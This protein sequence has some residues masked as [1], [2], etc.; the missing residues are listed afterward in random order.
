MVIIPLAFVAIFYLIVL[1]LGNHMLN[2]TVEE[3]ENRVTEMM[4]TTMSPTTMISGKIVA[5]AAVGLLQILVFV[6]IPVVALVAFRDK[7]QI[8]GLDLKDI[9]AEPTQV[10]IGILLLLGGLTLFT[11][12]LVAAGAVMPTAK[13]ASS[14]FGA[15]VVGLFIPFYAISLIVTDP[16]SLIVNIFTFFPLTAP[17]TAMA[18]NGL[19]NLEV[20]Q[21]VT[22]I[23]ILFATGTLMLMFAIR[24]F[25]HGSI[26]Y[27][28]KLNI[29]KAFTAK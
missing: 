15:V 10:V 13:E 18:R 9:S 14:I 26:S 21:A 20:W 2:I 29:L 4:L 28:N 23:G 17:V 7:M 22:V 11:G 12:C 25:K 19:G 27:S 24:L 16:N 1:M 3:K 5:V 8:P 6:T